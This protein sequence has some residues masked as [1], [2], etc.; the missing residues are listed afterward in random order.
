MESS[1]AELFRPKVMRFWLASWIIIFCL[2]FLFGLLAPDS[3]PLTI[4]KVGS[5]FLCLVYAFYHTP[6][7]FLLQSALFVTFIADIILAIENTS[8]FG[9]ILFFVAQIIH[10]RR[11][12]ITNSAHSQHLLLIL[13][14]SAILAT[15]IAIILRSTFTIYIICAFYLVAIIANIVLAWRWQKQDPKSVSAR[16]AFY[17]FALF[18]CCDICTGLSYLSL[19]HFL[20][21]F[22]YRPA[23]FFA[24]F[25][26]YPSQILVSNSSKCATINP[27]KEIVL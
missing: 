27:K 6:H 21:S 19:N 14:S 16:C 3:L 8:E 13:T 9:V 2:I 17:G 25:F 24:W 1:L 5:I 11:Q 18:L 26:Y 7:D 4:L 20:P 15:S 12:A 23:N 22:F 10:L